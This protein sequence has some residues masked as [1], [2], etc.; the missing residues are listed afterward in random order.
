MGPLNASEKLNWGFFFQVCPKPLPRKVFGGKKKIN[1]SFISL[2]RTKG[3]D[4]PQNF[5]K[6]N[7]GPKLLKGWLKESL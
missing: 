4:F 5:F 6:R 1:F 3:F 2:K 7:I